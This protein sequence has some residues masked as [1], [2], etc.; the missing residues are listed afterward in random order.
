M[1]VGRQHG[2]RERERE[3]EGKSTRDTYPSTW[4]SC[5]DTLI[6][7]AS[8]PVVGTKRSKINQQVIVRPARRAPA[9]ALNGNRAE[10]QRR[11]RE[12][13]CR[14]SP[15][16]VRYKAKWIDG[17]DWATWAA[18]LDWTGLDGGGGRA[19]PRGAEPLIAVVVTLEFTLERLCIRLH[20]S[21]RLPKY[22]ARY[23]SSRRHRRDDMT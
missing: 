19:F 5:G 1:R 15:L 9:P 23:S 17:I 11:A 22:K 10:K 12:T 16:F 7:V 2:W 4:P 13:T 14:R 18:G 6:H 3:R 8:Q 20:P 21:S